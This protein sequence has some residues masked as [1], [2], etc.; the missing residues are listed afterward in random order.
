M[1]CPFCD[2]ILT[3]LPIFYVYEKQPF[4]GEV[5]ELT[6]E[7]GDDILTIFPTIYSKMQH[8][9]YLGGGDYLCIYVRGLAKMFW[10]NTIGYIVGTYIIS[11]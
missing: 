1:T 8:S 9:M 5:H 11:D 7:F 3:D 6:V 2:D 4:I 10:P